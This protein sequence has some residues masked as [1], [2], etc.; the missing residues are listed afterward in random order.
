MCVVECELDIFGE[1]FVVTLGP[2]R[3]C[4]EW[5]ETWSEFLEIEV[6]RY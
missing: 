3:V 1:R 2:V 6:L 4:G 5:I